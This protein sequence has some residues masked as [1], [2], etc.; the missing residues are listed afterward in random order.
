L[1]GEGPARF[2]SDDLFEAMGIQP[3]WCSFGDVHSLWLHRGFEEMTKVASSQ[4]QFQSV[5][6]CG[7]IAAKPMP[8]TPEGLGDFVREKHDVMQAA[9]FNFLLRN[10]NQ[11]APESI[12]M[13]WETH[14][15]DFVDTPCKESDASCLRNSGGRLG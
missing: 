15:F 7:P 2:T 6:T 11:E 10:P 9:D 4:S 3:F 13:E 12:F 8:N 5:L 1:Q 14:W